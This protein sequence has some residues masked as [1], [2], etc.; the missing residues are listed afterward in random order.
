MK[1]DQFGNLFVTKLAIF[2]KQYMEIFLP[3][4]GDFELQRTYMCVMT[5]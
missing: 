5:E 4:N 3:K 2:Y 1:S